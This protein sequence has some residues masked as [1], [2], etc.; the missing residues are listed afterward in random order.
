MKRK[1]FAIIGLGRF[2]MSLACSLT[3]LGHQVLA[4]DLSK[5]KVQE[6]SEIVSHAIQIDAMDEG[7]LKDVGIRNFETVIVAIGQDIEASILVTMTLKD[8]GVKN[9]YTKA[10]NNRHQKVLEK[11]GADKV[12][13]PERDMAERL[14]HHLVAHNFL[15]YI[16]L[17]S[18]YGLMEMRP[19]SNMVGKTLKEINLRKKAGVSIIAIKK[20][21]EIVTA[22]GGNQLI[23]KDDVLVAIGSY[24]NFE[25]LQEGE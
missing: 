22:P 15:D 11:I 24:D 20:E 23:E 4:L 5:E 6:A 3:E 14:A 18:E 25:K 2:G 7:A 1:E 19:P 10:M 16:E 9:V 12:I 8:L 13:N 21:G 17:S